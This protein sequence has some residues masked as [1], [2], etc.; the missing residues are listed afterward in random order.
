ME[1]EGEREGPGKSAWGGRAWG[2]LWECME[3]QKS[4]GV[5][6]RVDSSGVRYLGVAGRS[7]TAKAGTGALESLES[8]ESLDRRGGVETGNRRLEEGEGG[9]TGNCRSRP[10]RRA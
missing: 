9:A 3:G 1:R 5:V 4:V 2:E 10:G 6:G 7:L 8:L